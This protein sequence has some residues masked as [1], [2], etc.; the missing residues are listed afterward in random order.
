MKYLWE[1]SSIE[2]YR[3]GTLIE[4]GKSRQEFDFIF[5]VKGYLRFK[6][7]NLSLDGVDCSI[8]STFVSVQEGEYI[9]LRTI[10]DKYLKNLKN[11]NIF[12]KVRL[13]STKLVA[14]SDL[15]ET[16]NQIQTNKSSCSP[17]KG[18]ETGQAQ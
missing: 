6:L 14:G 3:T 16:L 18:A 9:D 17:S 15:L 7:D 2:E 13:A 5:V 12:Q 10:T 4:M 1:V 8:K 11:P